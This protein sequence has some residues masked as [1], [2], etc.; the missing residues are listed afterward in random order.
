MAPNVCIRTLPEELPRAN[1]Y[2]QNV[3]FI[4]NEP[5]KTSFEDRPVPEIED[6]YD[7]IVEV[8]HTGI[9]GSDVIYNHPISTA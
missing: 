3:S 8:K 4:L 9:C 1:L 5:Y 7:V 2:V 6:P